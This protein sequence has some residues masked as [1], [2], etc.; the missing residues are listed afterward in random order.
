M[1]QTD[2]QT[3]NDGAIITLEEPRSVWC[4]LVELLHVKPTLRPVDSQLLQLGDQIR[5]RDTDYSTN[6]ILSSLS[7]NSTLDQ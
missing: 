1:R 7:R 6:M 2:V 5:D 4:W 3:A